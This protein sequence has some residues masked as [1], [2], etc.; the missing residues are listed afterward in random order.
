MNA[1]QIAI[2]V[3]GLV[4]A[5][6]AGLS[7]GKFTNLKCISCLAGRNWAYLES[8]A[9]SV[10]TC[11]MAVALH[12]N[13]GND[14]PMDEFTKI[15]ALLSLRKISAVEATHRLR[16]FEKKMKGVAL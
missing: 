6:L 13:A 4:L 9:L 12:H 2:V 10:S 14:K 1:I 11:A 15:L 8:F 3:I 5:Y 7:I 16:N